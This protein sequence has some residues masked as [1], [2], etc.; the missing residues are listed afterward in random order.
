VHEAGTEKLKSSLGVAT[1]D[2]SAAQTTSF[3][4]PLSLPATIVGPAAYTPFHTATAAMSF[5]KLYS[6]EVGALWSYPAL[7]NES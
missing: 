6:Y 4:P 2:P 1:L 5:G 7:K 3:F